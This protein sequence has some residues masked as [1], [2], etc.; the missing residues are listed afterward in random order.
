MR[1]LFDKKLSRRWIDLGTDGHVRRVR[2]W[3]ASADR[4]RAEA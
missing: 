1:A 3:L 4:P 2:V